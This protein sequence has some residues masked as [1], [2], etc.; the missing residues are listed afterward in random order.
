MYLDSDRRPTLT[1]QL[2]VR[3]AI[4]GGIALVAFAVVFFRLW[5]LQ[6]LSSD[7][8]R[9][10]AN[11]NRTREIKV[12][13]PR[14][15]IV[16]RE[17][18]KLVDNS[19]GLAVKVSPDRLPESRAERRELYTR[20]S[21]V[22][23]GDPMR[24]ERSIE[25]QLKALPFSSAT[26]KQGVPL[27]VVSFLLERQEDFPGVTVEQEFLR[28]YPYHETGAHLFGTVGEV[29][30]EQ[31][32]DERYRGVDMG[33]RVGQ[34]GIEYQYD[35]F[36][37]GE[38]GATRVQ[39]DAMGNL[40]ETLDRDRPKQGSQLRLS[41]D[42]DVQRAG[43]QALAGGTGR[44]AFVVM[45]VNNGEVRALGS[46]PSFDPN[47]FT[48]VIRKSDYERLSDPDLGAPLSNR[49]IQ[50]AYPTGSTF[51]LITATAALEGGLITPDTF[52]FD[53]GSLTVGGVTFKNAGDAAYGTLALRQ[54][55]TVSSDVF[56]YRLGLEANGAGDGLVLQTWAKRLGMGRKTGIDLPGELAGLIPTPRWRNALYRKKQT[57]RPWSAG[58]NIN[59]SVGQGDLQANP[60]QLAVAYAAIANGGKVLSP[61]I[62]QRIEDAGGRA[63]QELKAP[64]APRLPID[65]A[66]RQA[67][68][69][70][71]RGAASAPGGTSTDVFAGFPIPIA[72][73]T[74]TAEKGLGRAD[75]SW[76]VALAPYP[77][78][79]YVVAV[80]DEAGGFGAETAAPMA[81]TILAELFG[82]T[83]DEGS[84]GGGVSD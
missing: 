73:K 63:L 11:N 36:L 61:R 66:Y 62:G 33:D 15:E 40:T 41:I 17:G 19:I 31:L 29:T 21:R 42:L 3:V 75:Q 57:D 79:K 52:L 16:D 6:V 81:R 58:D 47:L 46:H 50:G 4:I 54:A 59:L 69:E 10:E 68:M 80:T 1:P 20:L 67:I 45:D 25:R 23:G 27:D 14:G 2:A 28:R 7:K 48:K 49:A 24:M 9:A 65:G 51:K 37:R 71:L 34:S 22:L 18:R 30:R 32:E 26:A 60:L 56:F 76:Y 53:G 83:G 38:N 84:E 74:G 39:V 43:Q 5:Y 78:P 64:A 12:Q 82:V 44:G 8:Y 70:G 35:R 72:G 13:A 77:S 55:L